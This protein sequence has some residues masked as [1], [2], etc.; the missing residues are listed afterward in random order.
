MIYC[1]DVRGSYT[2]DRRREYGGDK[3]TRPKNDGQSH[4]E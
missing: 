2:R 4:E 3:N 1:R